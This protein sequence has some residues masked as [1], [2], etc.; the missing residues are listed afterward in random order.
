MDNNQK[1]SSGRGKELSLRYSL[2]DAF[3]FSLMVGAGETYLP[4]YALS[5]GMSEWLTGLFA[6][7]PLIVGALIQLLS[8]WGLGRVQSVKL[9]VVG[10]TFVQALTFLPLL[11]LSLHPTDNFLWLFLI[12]ALYW[13][14]GFAAGPS[15]NFWMGHL[16]PP[17][18]AAEFFSRRHRVSQWGILVGLIGGGLALH[19]NVKFGPLTSVFSVL[20]LIAFIARASSSIFLWLKSDVIQESAAGALKKNPT[21]FRFWKSEARPFFVFLFVFYVTIYISSPFVTPYFLEKLKL[22]YDQYMLALAALLFAKIAVLPFASRLIERFGVAWIFFLGAIGISPLP[23]FWPVSPDMWLVLTLQILSGAFWGLFEVGITMIFFKQIRPEEKISILTIYNVFNALAMVI[24]T[25]IGGHILRSYNASLESYYMIFA[26]G[27]VL[28][29][30][31]I[32]AYWFGSR[33]ISF[34]KLQQ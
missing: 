13:G 14:A 31:T 32:T 12:A 17:E 10:S 15:W 1:I 8:P 6:T 26:I 25:I 9:W 23:V 20:F 3:F 19:W 18:K 33:K 30:F 29:T 7:A 24:G 11:Y 21:K 34:L 27:A 5:V 2:I 22:N 4:A 28:R 16:V